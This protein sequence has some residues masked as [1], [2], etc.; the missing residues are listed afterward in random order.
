MEEIERLKQIYRI[1][2]EMINENNL[3][4][5][6]NYMET[7]LFDKLE[8]NKLS[9]FIITYFGLKIELTWIRAIKAKLVANEFVSVKPMDPPKNS[10]FFFT[11]IFK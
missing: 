7:P 1:I 6:L 10:I 4:S 8:H 9:N 2:R 11:Q 5:V 3:I